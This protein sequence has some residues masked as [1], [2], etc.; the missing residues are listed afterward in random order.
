MSAYEVK[1]N[2]DEGPNERWNSFM[3]E[4]KK[5]VVFTSKNLIG[6]ALYISPALSVWY[7]QHRD[8]EVWLDTLPNFI[9]PI[10]ERMGV[11]LTLKYGVD[12]NFV[13]AGKWFD[14]NVN[15]AFR[16]CD[17]QKIHIAEAYA[18]MLGVELPRSPVYEW[19]HVKPI[20]LPTPEELREDEKGLILVSMFS[21]SCASRQGKPPNK[22]LPWYKWEP[23]LRY[24]RTWNTPIRFLGS[25]ADRAPNFLEIT[26]EEYL[27][28]VPLNRLALIMR[29]AKFVVTLDN[30]MSHLA[31]S[32]DAATFLFYPA[33]LGQHYILPKGNRYLAYVHMDPVY[34][35][36][37]QIIQQMQRTLPLLVEAKER[38]KTQKEPM[39]HGLGR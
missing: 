18:Q 37:P 4:E 23:I 33:C 38:L 19:A 25:K 3:A 34:V 29:A 36:T 30:G 22:M 24:L 14:F 11:P 9:A 20:F 39:V 1:T 6:D 16:I 2:I 32:Q 26:S 5:R 21:A 7:D 35:A 12:S 8:W 10:Y 31:A 13:S 28:G 15:E 17:E 27:T